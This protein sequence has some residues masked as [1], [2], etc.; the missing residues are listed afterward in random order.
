MWIITGLNSS[1]V[2]YRT[3]HG[4][5]HFRNLLMPGWLITSV[6]TEDEVVLTEDG[7]VLT[8][9]GVVLI[10]QVQHLTQSETLIKLNIKL[11]MAITP[12]SYCQGKVP[13][14]AHALGS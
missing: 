11:Y 8:E 2:I 9:D 5:I 10:V 14:L 3:L 4:L 7:V 6:L 1:H 13:V 12:L